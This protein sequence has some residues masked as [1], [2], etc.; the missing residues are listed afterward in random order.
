MTKPIPSF[1]RSRII[2]PTE[3]HIKE[4]MNFITQFIRVHIIMV[5]FNI[6]PKNIWRGNIYLAVTCVSCPVTPH[7]QC[8]RSAAI[9]AASNP[10]APYA[11]NIIY[12]NKHCLRTTRCGWPAHHYK[13]FALIWSSSLTQY[14]QTPRHNV[15]LSFNLFLSLELQGCTKMHRI[16]RTGWVEYFSPHTVHVLN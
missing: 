16:N 14:S 1:E 2:F 11:C 15:C 5:L 7:W 3:R 8:V 6:I 13:T 10:K 4:D 12:F 9:W